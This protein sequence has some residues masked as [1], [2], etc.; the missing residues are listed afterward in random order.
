VPSTSGLSDVRPPQRPGRACSAGQTAAGPSPSSAR[1]EPIRIGRRVH[2]LPLA[3][4]VAAAL[5]SAGCA[6]PSERTATD[7]GASPNADWTQPQL[8]VAARNVESCTKI[9]HASASAAAAQRLLDV[10]LPCLTAGPAV[11]PARL[12]GRPV[13]VNLWAT[14]C[15]PC[16]KEMPILQAAHDRYGARVQFL[17]VNT[18]DRP[19]WAAEFLQEVKVTYPQVVDSDGTLLNSLR[20]PG[21]PVTVVVDARGGIAGRQIGQI[22]E[23]RLTDLVAGATR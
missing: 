15:E 11:N 14:W 10:D 12:G 2:R 23:Q 21:L 6:A 5:L 13:V 20:S 9:S 16:R 17:G 1:A 19:E 8:P 7:N 4:A 18:K 22:S 3:L